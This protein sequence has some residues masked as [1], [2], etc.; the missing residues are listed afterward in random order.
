MS[1]K[2]IQEDRGVSENTIR[3]QIAHILAKT[4]AA[5][6]REL[7]KLLGSLPAA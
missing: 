2:Q 4:G 1:L 7:V 5:N 6:Q 3:T